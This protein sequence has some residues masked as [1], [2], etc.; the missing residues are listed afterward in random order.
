MFEKKPEIQATHSKLAA[1]ADTL[2]RGD[3]MPMTELERISGTT[4]YTESWNWLIHALK[5]YLL[6][7]RGIAIWPKTNGVYHLLTSNEQATQLPLWESRRELRRGKRL[8]RKVRAV[9]DDSLTV[10]QRLI[11][12]RQLD[13]M[14]FKNRQLY[15]QIHDGQP[16]KTQTLPK[17]ALVMVG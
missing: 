14:R 5:R 1:Y 11:K 4:R 7:S 10:Q 6:Q 17:R 16:R 9:P 8:A 13:Y 3:M 12:L 15:R 2:N